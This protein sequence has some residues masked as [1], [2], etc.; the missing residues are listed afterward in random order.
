[1]AWVAHF[2]ILNHNR[3]SVNH[4]SSDLRARAHTRDKNKDNKTG[5]VNQ[6]RKN[7]N[8]NSSEKRKKSERAS[9]KSG[10]YKF[11]THDTVLSISVSLGFIS[12]SLTHQ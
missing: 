3:N 12:F 10:F 5:P 7:N 6:N 1:M 4:H 11:V 8:N 9:K 2:L